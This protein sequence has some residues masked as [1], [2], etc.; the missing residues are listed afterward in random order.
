M[1]P[2]FSNIAPCDECGA[3]SGDE[4]ADPCSQ[5]DSTKRFRENMRKADDSLMRLAKETGARRTMYV[6]M[7]FA[8]SLQTGLTPTEFADACAKAI[9]NAMQEIVA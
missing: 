7:R 8:M 9:E 3:H 4:H 6:M 2:A 1:H 5:S